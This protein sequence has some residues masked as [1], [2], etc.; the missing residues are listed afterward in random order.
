MRALVSS[1][2]VLVLAELYAWFLLTVLMDMNHHATHAWNI[3]F[4]SWS[5][6]HEHPKPAN[7][8]MCSG[9]QPAPICLACNKVPQHAA[10]NMLAVN[11]RANAMQS[12]VILHY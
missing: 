10:A 6:L 2:F 11:K 9:L 12:G 7:S 3:R 5:T 4:L 8:N 1:Q